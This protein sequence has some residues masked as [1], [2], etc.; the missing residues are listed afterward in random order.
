M[1]V[2]TNE[3]QALGRGAPRGLDCGCEELQVAD[4]DAVAAWSSLKIDTSDAAETGIVM[5][6]PGGAVISVNDVLLRM[7]GY[8]SAG[9]LQGRPIGV[10]FDSDQAGTVLW[11]LLTSKGSCSCE[12]DARRGDG[13]HFV[14]HF[15][16]QMVRGAEGTPTRVMVTF[17]D[18][19]EQK[20]EEVA[21]RQQASD[22]DAYAQMVAHDLANPLARIIGYAEFLEAEVD[23]F[24]PAELAHYLHQIVEAG[25]QANRT[26]QGLLLLARLRRADAPVVEPLDMGAI[27]QQVLARLDLLV[28]EY[29][30]EVVLPTT[31][32]EIVGYGPW[33]EQVWENYLTNAL[34][35]GG[36]PPHV[37]LGWSAAPTETAAPR[38]WV[39]DNGSGIPREQWAQ[40]FVP[41]ARLAPRS[42]RGHGLGLSIA[43][44]IVETL[45][46]EVGLESEPGKGSTF[47]FTLPRS[48]GWCVDS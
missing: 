24:S 18:V 4:A 38:F 43:R 42:C 27:V 12:L 29:R 11:R 33:V 7:W 32:P 1:G 2:T 10:L 3:P 31:W 37:V 25:N 48:G 47:W 15:S 19:T 6:T 16:A 26:V 5:T 8:A 13:S 39:R 45:G 23:Q 36:R 20:Q 30:P 44:Q 35:Y 40:L 22:L 17:V 46:G 21:L 14:A 28:E 34:K 9:D 41:F